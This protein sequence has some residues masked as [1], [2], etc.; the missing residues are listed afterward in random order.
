MD[1]LRDLLNRAKSTT[2]TA[3]QREEQRQSFAYGNTKFENDRITREMISRASRE[4]A[5]DSK[6]LVN[7]LT[8]FVA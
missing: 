3:A 1:N 4:L 5:A 8:A 6:L 2:M 7:Q